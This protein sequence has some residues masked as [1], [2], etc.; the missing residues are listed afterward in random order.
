MPKPSAGVRP[1]AASVAPEEAVALGAA[2]QAGI[3]EGAI[4]QLDVFSVFEAAFIR[5]LAGGGS[6]PQ[7]ERTGRRRAGK[8]QAGL[9][10]PAPAAGAGAK[11][12]P[13][14]RGPKRKR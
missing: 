12:T 6:R 1:D 11:L 5:G 10:G 13:G 14:K 7:R 8:R 2:V 4:E 3:L 9:I